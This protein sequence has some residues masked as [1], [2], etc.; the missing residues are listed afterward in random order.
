MS[1]TSAV[2]VVACLVTSVSA[3]CTIRECLLHDPV[4]REVRPGGKRPWFS[5]AGEGDS[6]PDTGSAEIVEL[7][8]VSRD[9]T[10][11]PLVEEFLRHAATDRQ[12][13]D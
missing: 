3:S 1:R 7:S 10:H 8:L 6:E 2:P 9:G 11:E 13:T 5:L 4:G 12:E